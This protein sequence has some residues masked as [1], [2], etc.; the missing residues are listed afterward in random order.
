M[1]PSHRCLLRRIAAR[2]SYDGW[3]ASSRYGRPVMRCSWRE[4][5]PFRAFIALGVSVQP[6]S[7][8]SVWSRR[9]LRRG[10]V[11]AGGGAGCRSRCGSGYGN[12]RLQWPCD[13]SCQPCRRSH[14]RSGTRGSRTG[15]SSRVAR[16]P[17]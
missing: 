13:G 8:A 6:R 3:V 12:A 16:P 17:G 4:L 15:R 2:R 5:K 11:S 7:H 1:W 10:A 14:W 9:M